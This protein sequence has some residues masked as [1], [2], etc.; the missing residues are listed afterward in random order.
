MNRVVRVLPPK[1]V[2][3]CILVLAV[4]SVSLAAS[5]N[6]RA[7][8]HGGGCTSSTKW[9]VTMSACVSI[10][11]FGFLVADAYATSQSHTWHDC[12]FS[13]ISYRDG[14]PLDTVQYS[15]VYSF[16]QGL[17]MHIAA[18]MRTTSPNHQYI[19]IVEIRGYQTDEIYFDNLI[20]S[21]TQYT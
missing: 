4:L 2:L 21:P 7:Y 18:P 19:D 11:S 20:T 10:D 17:S 13:I 12:T 6:A 9:P 3:L 8:T 16:Q 5:P 15:C 14:Y 1:V